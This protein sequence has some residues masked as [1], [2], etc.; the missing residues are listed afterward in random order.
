MLATC[1]ARLYTRGDLEPF[2]EGGGGGGGGR[3]ASLKFEEGDGCP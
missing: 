3:M 1:S 2:P